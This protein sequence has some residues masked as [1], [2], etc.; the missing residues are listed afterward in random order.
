MAQNVNGAKV[1]EPCSQ[2]TEKAKSW[3]MEEGLQVVKHLLS[4][5]HLPLYCSLTDEQQDPESCKLA[6]HH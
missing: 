6:G 4:C 5:G 3:M 1:E 2:L